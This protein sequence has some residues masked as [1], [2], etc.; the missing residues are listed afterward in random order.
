MTTARFI[1]DSPLKNIDLYYATRFLA[2][3]PVAFF[4]FKGKK[5]LVLDA[6]EIDRA[7]KQSIADKVLLASDY[8]KDFEI[9]KGNVI[10]IMD[11]I[12]K[13]LGIK[14][15]E[16]PY[17]FPLAVANAFKTKK[18][19]MTIGPSPFYPDRVQKKPLEKKAILE[20]QKK[21]FKLMALSE[22]VIRQSK[23]KNG[24]LYFKGKTLTSELLKEILQIEAI[25][26]G[27][28]MKNAIIVACGKHAIDPHDEGSGP[29]KQ[30]QAIIVDIFPM[31]SKTLFY[32][33]ATR[34]F[35]KGTAPIALKR[36]YAVV[37]YAQEMAIGM[38]RAGINGRSI[39]EKIVECF[40][41]KGYKTG[42]MDGRQQ[43]FIHST[44]HG[45][46][47]ELHE[48][49]PSIGTKDCILKSGFTTSVEPGLYYKKIG[50]VRIE[51]LVY[52]T[53]TGCEVLGYYPKHLEI[54]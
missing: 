21:V 41:L 9:R 12:F 3:D 48:Y 26:L 28:E 40:D 32:G 8:D 44:G 14:N 17:N 43:G 33:D 5:Y 2:H 45:I 38:I 7:K 18:Y 11:V 31:S 13:K 29:I 34:T 10:A 47:L 35:C 4:E 50:G 24:G 6:L 30:G 1:Y 46:G 42:E 49:P 23:V 15:L 53:K 52:V 25:Q 51:D 22:N 54:P 39:H 16:V 20:A 37:K 36:M 27:L 19:K